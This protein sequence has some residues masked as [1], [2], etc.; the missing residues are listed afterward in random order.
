MFGFTGRAVRIPKAVYERARTRARAVG[1]E[2][3]ADYIAAL[4]DRDAGPAPDGAAR[5]RILERLRSL[6]YAADAGP[7]K[8]PQ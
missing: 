2:S 8:P 6:G 5:E 7:A 4:V 3:V 1:A